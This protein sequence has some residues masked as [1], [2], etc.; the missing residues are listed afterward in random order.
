MP[1][2]KF[3]KQGHCTLFGTQCSGIVCP[4]RAQEADA[5]QSA[6]TLFDLLEGEA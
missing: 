1:P 5:Q 2:C 6:P 3:N 4:H